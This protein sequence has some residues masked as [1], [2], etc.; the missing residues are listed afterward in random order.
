MVKDNLHSQICFTSPVVNSVEMAP[1]S[2]PFQTPLT[3]TS[4]VDPGLRTWREYW[5]RVGWRRKVVFG[6][7]TP[8]SPYRNIIWSTLALGG[9]H[10]TKATVSEMS[11]TIS[12]VGPS[13]TDG[14]KHK[15]TSLI[16]IKSELLNM[17]EE[18]STMSLKTPGVHT[19][20][21]GGPWRR[22]RKHTKLSFK[23]WLFK[24]FKKSDKH[25]II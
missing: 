8:T 14:K 21:P 1:L 12:C 25:Y 10:S 24:L 2:V 11:R 6:P 15:T 3:D 7:S 18:F 23:F 22:Y 16:W 4:Y 13:I 19:S 9:L 5:L 20:T 17:L